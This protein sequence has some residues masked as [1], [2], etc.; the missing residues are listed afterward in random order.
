MKFAFL[1]LLAFLS[2]IPSLVFG[3]GQLTLQN[4]VTG[5]VIAPIYGLIPGAE[6][7]RRTGNTAVGTPAGTA[8]YGSATLLSGT[9]Y[10]AQLWVGPSGSSME[11]LVLANG[12][13]TTSFRT[14]TGAGFVVQPTLSAEVPGVP[15]G[16]GTRCAFQVRA[17]DNQG[18][19]ITSWAQ[20]VSSSTAVGF[21]EVVQGTF[22]LGGGVTLP[23][24]GLVGLTSFN[25]TLNGSYTTTILTNPQSRSVFVG[26][27]ASLQVVASSPLPLNYL[28]RKGGVVIPGQNS[29]TLTLPSVSLADAG[30]YDVIVSNAV[31]IATSQAA[32]LQ[33]LPLNAPSI[34]VNSQPALGTVNSGDPATVTITPGFSGGLIFYTLD[35]SMPTTASSVY[36]NGQPFQLRQN[37]TVRA[38][39][40]S[41]DFTQSAE[42]PAVQVRIVA[43]FSLTVNVSGNGTVS[44]DPASGPYLSN[45]TVRLT[46]L[47]KSYAV[48]QGW[49]GDLTGSAN[50]ASLIMN[51]NRTVTALFNQTHYPLSVGTAGG[52]LV[53]A[54]GQVITNNTFYT[55]GSVVTLQAATNP[56][57]IFVGWQ[58][59]TNGSLNPLSIT[60]N[61]TQNVQAVF[62][63]TVSTNIL[64]NGQVRFNPT[65]PIPYGTTVTLTAIPAIGSFFKAWNL[66]D[67]G[68]VTNNPT[69]LTV[70]NS[71]TSVGAVFNLYPPPLITTQPTNLSVVLGNPASFSVV[72]T[73]DGPLSYQWRLGG[74]NLPARTNATLA[75]AGVLESDAGPY[76]VVVLN[77]NGGSVTSSVATLTVWVPPAIVTPPS[78]LT[79]VTGSN[80]L[81]SVTARGTGPLAY[82][83]RKGGIPRVGQVGTTYALSNV[84]SNDAGPYDV[85]VTNLY[86]SVISSVATLT[87]VSPPSILVQPTGGNFAAGGPLTLSVT[88]DGTA[89]LSYQ[90]RRNGGNVA[91]GSSAVYSLASATTN[92][93]GNYS[94]VVSNPYGAVTSAVANVL[95]YAR[96]V[97]LQSPQPVVVTNKG[98]AVFTAAVSGTG[99]LSYQ[100]FFNGTVLTGQVQSTLTLTNVG[101]ND[102]G[103][104]LIQA[105]NLYSSVSSLPARLWMSPSL[106]QPFVGESAIWGREV[107]LRVGAVGSAPLGYRWY[108][109]GVALSQGTNRTLTFLNIQFGDA[110][111]YSVVITNPVGVITN[112]PAQVVVNPAGVELGLY[113]GI[114]VDGQPG[115]TYAIQASTNLTAT[116]QWFTLTNLT[117]AQTNELWVDTSVNVQNRNGARRYY[118]VVPP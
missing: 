43:A 116:N 4:R 64:G 31:G 36:V 45:A 95:V 90:W 7:E 19:T 59:T 74:T 49:S 77:V 118:R 37:A 71:G 48:F 8:N 2:A 66:P 67:V 50:P 80:A 79:V 87:V 65:N 56:G 61:R 53:T 55:N 35:G 99:P 47:P 94:V 28:W 54:N 111:L 12:G 46:A 60:M 75:F 30:L 20:A 29:S 21:S 105:Y 15:G 103:D 73:G 63:T 70:T 78:S 113:A 89:P 107:T 108:K 5:S 25:L 106:T 98:T 96:V 88:A 38:M 52:G 62:A 9:S 104:Y 27:P 33:V 76:D 57:W 51:G 69:Q 68:A 22:D 6:T 32:V 10:T 117:L 26:F 16:S 40:L 42:A 23:N 18:G 17:W 34:R 102:L 92:D 72:A 85:V 93:S 86:G 24:P 3:Q 115:Y 84:T 13:N 81:F 41:A 114:R 110:G 58:G 11:Q 97:F 100:W 82:Q 101:T 83:W 14:G 39:N 1:T 44:L 91:G 112:P 109:N